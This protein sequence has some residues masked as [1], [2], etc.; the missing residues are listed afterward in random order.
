VCVFVCVCVCVCVRTYI[1]IYVCV[2]AR[3][4]WLK[5]FRKDSIVCRIH[6][7]YFRKLFP[8]GISALGYFWG[9][10]KITVLLQSQEF[11][12]RSS[13]TSLWSNS[14]SDGDS[15]PRLHNYRDPLFTPT[16]TRAWKA[17]CIVVEPPHVSTA[18][19]HVARN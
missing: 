9:W 8:N 13:E 7:G 14:G 3:T 15:H 11:T 4:T 1:Y 6:Q 19:R 2:C 12:R 18:T 17:V 10:G 16:P 5:R